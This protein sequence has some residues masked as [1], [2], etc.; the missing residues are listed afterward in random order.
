MSRSRIVLVLVGPTA[1]GKTAVGAALAELLRGEIISADSRQVYRYLDV[2]TAKPSRELRGR[3]PH[4]FVD[5]ILPDRV[6]SAGEF[7]VRG[8]EVVEEVFARGRIP[9]VVGGSGLYIQS[10]VDGF[11]EG[12]GADRELRASLERRLA[13]EGVDVL[14]AELARVDPEF[15]AAVDRTKPRRI[16]RGLEVFALTGEPISRRQKESRVEIVFASQMFGLEWDRTVLYRRINARCDEMLQTGLLAEVERLEARG[17]GADLNA[18]KTVGYAEAFAYRSGRI[19]YDEMVR[20]FKQNSRRYAKRQMTW[21]RR[22]RRIRWI[23]ME[24]HRTPG[25]VAAE[26]SKI[27]Q[28]VSV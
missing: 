4:H 21:F 12:P 24:E 6:F 25:D 22:D 17:Y 10:L 3:V 23:R 13:D 28:R 15:A 14:L 26:I 19:S 20:L 5:E 2:G 11:F 1:S 16:I 18:L 7:G 9:I 27:F 8:R